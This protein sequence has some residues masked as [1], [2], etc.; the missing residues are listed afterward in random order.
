MSKFRYVLYVNGYSDKGCY[1]TKKDAL[2]MYR[3]RK[4][5]MPSG[6]HLVLYK[7]WIDE[8]SILGC[9]CLVIK[10][11]RVKKRKEVSK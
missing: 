1:K 5:L 9:D 10:E 4:S 6:T 8:Y 3:I 11:T 7:A 2:K